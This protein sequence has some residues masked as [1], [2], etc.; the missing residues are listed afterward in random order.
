VIV[1]FKR[2]FAES[3]ENAMDFE[4]GKEYKFFMSYYFFKD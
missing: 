2:P 3:S 1:D 4:P